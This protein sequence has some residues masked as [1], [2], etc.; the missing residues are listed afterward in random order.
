[1]PLLAQIPGRGAEYGGIDWCNCLILSTGYPRLRARKVLPQRGLRLVVALRPDS[2][3]RFGP[4][5]ECTSP[6]ITSVTGMAVW[7]STNVAGFDF[8]GVDG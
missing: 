4:R 8:G 7:R 3:V 1:M 2:P 6:L 5:I